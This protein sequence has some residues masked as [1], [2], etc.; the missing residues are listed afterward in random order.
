MVLYEQTT[1]LF[2][3]ICVCMCERK[4]R[5]P[6]RLRRYCLDIWSEELFFF[7]IYCIST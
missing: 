6:S 3:T 7:F 5:I 4:L 2:L 1:L